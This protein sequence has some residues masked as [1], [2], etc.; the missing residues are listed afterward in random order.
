MSRNHLRKSN[1]DE[2]GGTHHKAVVPQIIMT[3]HGPI[4][5]LTSKHVFSSL[6]P[7]NMCALFLPVTLLLLRDPLSVTLASCEHLVIVIPSETA[8]SAM[9]YLIHLVLIKGCNDTHIQLHSHDNMLHVQWPWCSRCGKLMAWRIWAC[10]SEFNHSDLT[11][12]TSDCL[13]P[14]QDKRW[15]GAVLECLT[16]LSLKYKSLL[17]FVLF[18]FCP[19]F[20][21]SFHLH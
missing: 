1:S 16:S 13:S 4:P 14:Q 20:W 21:Q 2:G 15:N 9:L 5:T 18:T 3:V 7:T 12:H 10:W 8:G 6:C 17:C 11:N 19:P